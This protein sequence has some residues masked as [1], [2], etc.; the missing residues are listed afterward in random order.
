M[1]SHASNGDQGHGANLPKSFAFWSLVIILVDMLCLA[2]ITIAILVASERAAKTSSIF[3]PS[4][5]GVGEPSAGET[6]YKFKNHLVASPLQV[7]LLQRAWGAA[8]DLS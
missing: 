3:D 5:F 1:A 6:M 8:S 4:V 7:M 2:N